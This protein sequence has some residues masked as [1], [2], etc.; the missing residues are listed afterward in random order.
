MFYA[1]L[2]CWFSTCLVLNICG[3]IFS[4]QEVSA[5]SSSCSW[6]LL[7]TTPIIWWDDEVCPLLCVF[8]FSSVVSSLDFTFS[9]VLR[10]LISGRDLY[11]WEFV[12]DFEGCTFF[13]SAHLPNVLGLLEITRYGTFV[14]SSW[15]LEWWSWRKIC[16]YD[17][18][19]LIGGFGNIICFMWLIF[20]SRD[21]KIP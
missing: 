7:G 6:F 13:M 10:V 15:K 16:I 17:I 12:N 21:W 9:L 19:T 11:F 2:A 18:Q 3:A 20:W 4:V 5:C 1:T 8:M 14:R